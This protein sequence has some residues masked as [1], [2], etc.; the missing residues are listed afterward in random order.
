MLPLVFHCKYI[1]PS[2]LGSPGDLLYIKDRSQGPGGRGLQTNTE[3]PISLQHRKQ[4]KVASSLDDVTM[5]N[6]PTLCLDS[7]DLEQSHMATNYE[8][9]PE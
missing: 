5:D 7:L 8:G 6:V 2:T 9:A 1:A 4:S 3:N